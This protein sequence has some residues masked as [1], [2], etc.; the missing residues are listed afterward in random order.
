MEKHLWKNPKSFTF[1]S[2]C[3]YT[4]NKVFFFLEYHQTHFPGLFCLKLK[5]GKISILGDHIGFFQRG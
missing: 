1:L 3:F 4:L 5:R 2:R